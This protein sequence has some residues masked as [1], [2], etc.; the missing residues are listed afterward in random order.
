MHAHHDPPGLL[1]EDTLERFVKSL[2]IFRLL[3]LPAAL[4]I[5]VLI[6]VF[7][8]KLAQVGVIRL[9]AASQ[10]GQAWGMI[11]ILYGIPLLLIG[12]WFLSMKYRER[13]KVLVGANL[14]ML[15]IIAWVVIALLTQSPQHL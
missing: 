12:G 15:G 5:A 2:L 6:S 14:A 3:L 1:L 7:I 10:D 11:V 4:C 8:D 9:S 13:A